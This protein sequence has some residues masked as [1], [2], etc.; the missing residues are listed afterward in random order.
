[1]QK[2]HICKTKL[3]Y[4]KEGNSDNTMDISITINSNHVIDEFSS[5]EIEKYF[6]TNSIIRGYKKENKEDK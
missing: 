5:G 2:N 4:S 1:M 3:K 6:V